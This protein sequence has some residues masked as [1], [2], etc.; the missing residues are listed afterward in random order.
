MRKYW[1]I[2]GGI[3][4]TVAVT[5]SIQAIPISGTISMGG[6]ATLDNSDL[7]QATTVTG[8][9]LVY[10]VADSGAFT[11]V[12]DFSFVNMTAPF[13]F[14]PA[15][16]VPLSDLWNV[17]GFQFDFQSDT[18]TQTAD[19][20][21]IIGYGTLSGNS[22]DPTAFQWELSA[23]EPTTGGPVQITF[24]ATAGASS[25]SNSVPDGGLTVALLG[26]ALAGME[27]LRRKLSKA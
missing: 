2:L 19:F 6:E 20:L 25:A 17:G 23:E 27:G 15:P 8:W 22:Y 16:G 1:A 21:T 24:S 12:S 18:V 3:V 13:V 14:S 9:P 4:A 5:T 11:T 26:L 7:S 10:V